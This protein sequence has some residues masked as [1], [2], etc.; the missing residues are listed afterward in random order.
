MDISAPLYLNNRYLLIK[1]G[2]NGKE[3]FKY[4]LTKE[5]KSRGKRSWDGY[6]YP[7]EQ[8]FVYVEYTEDVSITV[9]LKK[10]NYVI[11]YLH[12]SQKDFFDPLPEDS[13][14]FKNNNRK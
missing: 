2:I 11:T 12:V 13:V 5:L 7:L 8:E 14:W 1:K 3:D 4:M 6:L 9:L 10:Y